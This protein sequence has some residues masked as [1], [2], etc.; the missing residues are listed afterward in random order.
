[1]QGG[2]LRAL[3]GASK[4]LPEPG[5]CESCFDVGTTRVVSTRWQLTPQAVTAL[6]KT[7]FVTG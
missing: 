7:T 6:A 3:T 4:S 2:N 1:V 5:H